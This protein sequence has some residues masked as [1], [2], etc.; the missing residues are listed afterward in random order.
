MQFEEMLNETKEFHKRASK[1]RL[2]ENKFFNLQRNRLSIV[3][4]LRE[5]YVKQ[6]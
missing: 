6:K 1:M 4:C 2:T 5:T 3:H